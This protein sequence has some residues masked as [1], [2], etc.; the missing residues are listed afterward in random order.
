MVRPTVPSWRLSITAVVG[1]ACGFG[2]LLAGFAGASLTGLPGVFDPS[3][4]AAAVEGVREYLAQVRNGSLERLSR[5]T[6]EPPALVSVRAD[7]AVG[8]DMPFEEQSD[9]FSPTDMS[10]IGAV[11]HTMRGGMRQPSFRWGDP[12][13]TVTGARPHH[14]SASTGQTPTRPGATATTT[15]WPGNSREGRGKDAT[16]SAF[17]A[18]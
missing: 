7:T 18:P 9:P 12:N 11:D 2:C 4:E 6:V 14:S 17:P 16:K 13:L 10:G 8:P 5:I 3:L 15:P 1:A